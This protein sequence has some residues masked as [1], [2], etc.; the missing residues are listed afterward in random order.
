MGVSLPG[1]R[2]RFAARATCWLRIGPCHRLSATHVVRRSAVVVPFVSDGLA[3]LE[4]S[5]GDRNGATEIAAA[6][7]GAGA[8]FDRGPSRVCQPGARLRTATQSRRAAQ[9][10]NG[11]R[12]T[13][14]LTL[15]RGNAPAYTH[16]LLDGVDRDVD[17]SSKIGQPLG[18]PFSEIR[19][20]RL[21]L[22]ISSIRE[23]R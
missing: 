7:S 4:R 2:G 20:P 3:A 6:Y 8:P 21:I 10:P 9:I 14:V 13:H 15:R 1:W 18:D 23:R 5:I 12:V 16:L 17:V 19:A 11:G 22:R